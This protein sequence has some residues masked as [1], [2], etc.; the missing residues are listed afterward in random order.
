METKKLKCKYCK[1]KT[2]HE[3]TSHV[4]F[5]TPHRKKVVEI[6]KC[7]KCEFH[8]RHRYERRKNPGVRWD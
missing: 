1:T 5:N 2:T 4:E 8:R 6:V 7:L 3:V